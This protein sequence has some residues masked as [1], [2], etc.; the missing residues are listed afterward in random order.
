MSF[1]FPILNQNLHQSA[2]T[3]IRASNQTAITSRNS[4][5]AFNNLPVNMSSNQSGGRSPTHQEK[6]LGEFV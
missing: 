3:T 1:F 2:S 5:L 6:L 4:T